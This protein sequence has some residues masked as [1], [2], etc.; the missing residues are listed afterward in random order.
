[1]SLFE[2]YSGHVR[3]RA[4]AIVIS[5][6]RILLVNQYVPA[7][8]EPV[9]LPPGGGIEVGES[10]EN[11]LIREVLEETG[12]QVKPIQLRYIHEFIQDNIHAYE[13]YYIAEVVGG[14]L[15]SGTDPEHSGDEQLI[16]SV[17]WNFLKNLNDIE[18]FPGFLRDEVLNKS[19]LLKT[20]SHFSSR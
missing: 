2:R 11:A 1:M 9:W 15:K 20:I 17:N 6:E 18:L 13:L 12:I 10:A 5:E 8:S 7:R 14:T 19:L 16:R 3:V 4:A